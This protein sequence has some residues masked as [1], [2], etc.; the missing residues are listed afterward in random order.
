[1]SQAAKPRESLLLNLVCNIAA[2]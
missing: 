2:P 1:M